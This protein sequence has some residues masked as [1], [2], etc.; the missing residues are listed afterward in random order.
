MMQYRG[1]KITWDGNRWVGYLNA[2]W[3]YERHLRY[4]ISDI[5]GLYEVVFE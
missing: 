4:L 2:H 1:W 3:F 5:D